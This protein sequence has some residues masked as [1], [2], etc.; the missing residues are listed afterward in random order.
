MEKLHTR[1]KG[2]SPFLMHNPSGMARGAE[3]GR[4]VI[5][6]PEDEAK[7]SRYLLPDGNF[8]VKAIAVR[9]SILSGAKGYRVRKMRASDIIAG[10]LLIINQEFPLLRDDAPINGENYSV[11]TQRAVVQRQ[12]ILRS[13]ARIELPWEIDCLFEYDSDLVDLSVIKQVA[14]NAG[15]VVGVGDYRIEKK[16]C[17]GRYELAD[18]WVE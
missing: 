14:N 11:D 18:I 9:N 1:L 12:G 17:Y 16:G 10:A 15:K 7:A 5:P 2:L 4:K 8:Y 13:R 6:T 3:L